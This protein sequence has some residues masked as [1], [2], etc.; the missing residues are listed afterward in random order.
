MTIR[1]LSFQLL[2][3]SGGVDSMCMFHIL[4]R[5]RDMWSPPLKLS[6]VTFNHKLRK[7]ADE[8]V[9]LILSTMLLTIL[10]NP[11]YLGRVCVLLVR[12]VLDSYVNS[13]TTRIAAGESRTSS[14]SQRLETHRGFKNS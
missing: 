2:S 4:A 14:Y 13:S 11:T 3:V 10:D 12:K 5:A 1:I 7:E 6:V 9:T 8:E